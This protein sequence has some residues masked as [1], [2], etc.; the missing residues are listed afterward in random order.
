MDEGTD[1]QQQWKMLFDQ[2]KTQ[3]LSPGQMGVDSR[4]VDPNFGPLPM[5]ELERW[6]RQIEGMITSGNPVLQKE[7]LSMLAQYRQ[8]A[9]S[10]I[11][12]ERTS[13][14]KEY[15]YALS[16]GFRGSFQEWLALNPKGTTVNIGDKG[17][18]SNDTLVDENG[19]I[20]PIPPTM[21]RTQAA[22]Q[23]LTYGN[24]QTAEEAKQSAAINTAQADLERLQTLLTDHGADLSGPAG[25]VKEFRGGSSIAGSILNAAIDYTIGPMSP[26]DVEALSTSLGLSNTILQAYRGAQVGPTEQILFNKQLPIPGQPREVLMANIERSKRNLALLQA[27]KKQN[28]GFY[29]SAEYNLLM[30]EAD[31]KTRAEVEAAIR[32]DKSNSKGVK[33]GPAPGQVWE[34]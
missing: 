27:L 30:S 28:R 26:A 9:N 8:Q 1:E 11:R 14:I 10:S 23:G 29:G 20:V 17:F 3:G 24:E 13:G 4:G 34:N 33:N 31:P 16:Q 25:L 18:S 15:E 6:K 21:T 12:D 5:S 32:K 19:N 22:E 7:G 2:G